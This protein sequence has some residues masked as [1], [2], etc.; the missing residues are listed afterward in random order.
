MKSLWSLLVWTVIIPGCGTDAPGPTVIDPE[1]RPLMEDWAADCRQHLES[2]RCNTYGIKSIT[3]VDG[4]GDSSGTIGRCTVKI[5]GFN[6]TK[7]IQIER[8]LPRDSMLMKSVILHEMIHCRFD[9]QTHTATGIMAEFSDT[10]EN[11][12][13]NWPELLREAYRLVE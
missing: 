10:E 13:S 6:Q 1:L 9:F 4:F 5:R 2:R 3:L 12:T 11:L 7:Y 8:S